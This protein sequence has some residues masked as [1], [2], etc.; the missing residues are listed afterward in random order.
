MLLSDSRF[1]GDYDSGASEA[2]QTERGSAYQVMM[3]TMRSLFKQNVLDIFY[4]KETY[5]T[6]NFFYD[7]CKICF[8]F[9]STLSN[10]TK[11]KRRTKMLM[12]V[13]RNQIVH[14]RNPYIHKYC[15]CIHLRMGAAI[16]CIV[17]MVLYFFSVIFHKLIF[18]IFFSKGLSLYF[19]IVSFQAKSR[20]YIS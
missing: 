18:Y 20:E 16:S 12:P 14:S 6:Y 5:N 8:F 1:G 15:G 2:T 3:F 10:N 11:I 19:A 13:F 4:L 17:W 7:L 9:F